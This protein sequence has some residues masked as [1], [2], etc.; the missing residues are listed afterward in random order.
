LYVQGRGYLSNYDQ[1]ENVDRAISAF[2]LALEKDPEYA[3][4][5]AG[6]GM[7]FW[8]RYEHDKIPRWVD[9]ASRACKGAVELNEE[10]AAAHACLGTVYSGTGRYTEAAAEFGWAMSLDSTNDA[11][12]RGLAKVYE[13]GGNPDAAEVVYRKAI[14]ERPHYWAA[15]NWLGSFLFRHGRVDEAEETLKEVIALAPDSYR[16]YQNLGGV[17]LLQGKYPEAIAVLERSVELTPTAHGYSNLASAYFGQ[18]RFD[19]SAHYNEKAIEFGLNDYAVWGNL[20]EAYYWIPDQRSKSREPYRRAVE[21]AGEQLEVNPNDAEI[22][23]E[24]A[25][26]HAMLGERERALECLRKGE[27]LEPP[28]I[29]FALNAAVVHSQLGETVSAL[30]WLEESRERGMSTSWIRDNPVFDS[31]R[32]QAR[33][34]QLIQ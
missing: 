4:A 27:E 26:F 18:R 28:G 34:Q 10:L 12:Y 16:G 31:L 5:R 23:G 6:L 9:R 24:L 33:F 7:A 17:Y 32:G 25:K 19:L 30:D 21:L 29:E 3:Q 20:G 8:K 2:E 15:Y 1:T 14:V 22:L 11:A 13:L